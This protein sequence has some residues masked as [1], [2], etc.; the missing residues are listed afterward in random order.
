MLLN[1]NI[2]NFFLKY[3]NNYYIIFYYILNPSLSKY[4]SGD[5]TVGTLF[6]TFVF[7]KKSHAQQCWFLFKKTVKRA[8]VW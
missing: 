8:K 5:F 3:N 6:F 4:F 7:N 1:E 2:Y